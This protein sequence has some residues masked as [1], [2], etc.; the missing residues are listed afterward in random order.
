[1]VCKLLHKCGEHGGLL[2]LNARKRQLTA[3]PWPDPRSCVLSAGF[4]YPPRRLPA[5]GC[6]ARKWNQ[7]Y[8][9]TELGQSDACFRLF[10]VFSTPCTQPLSLGACI[11]TR[12]SM[13]YV[14]WSH[15]IQVD[16]MHWFNVGKADLCVQTRGLSTRLER[17]RRSFLKHVLFR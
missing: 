6:S 7:M 13:T 1:M 5:T 17:H 10:A 16:S 12:G 11:H 14:L 9:G 15:Q 4:C 3:P 2:I 8:V